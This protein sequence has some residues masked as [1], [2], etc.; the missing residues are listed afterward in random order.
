MTS[1][2]HILMTDTIAKRTKLIFSSEFQLGSI[3]L[4]IGKSIQFIKIYKLVKNCS[5]S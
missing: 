4:I 1:S 2:P 5:I 3:L